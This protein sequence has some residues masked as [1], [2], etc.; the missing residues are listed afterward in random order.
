Q[1]LIELWRLIGRANKYLDETEPWALA[2]E[3]RRE[4]L[5]TV[6]YHVLETQRIV[7]LL[8]RPFMPQT[9]AKIWDQLGIEMPL[10]EQ[11]LDATRWGGLVPGTRVRPAPP[12]FPRLERE[13]DA[14][15]GET[16][17]G[18]EA[19]RAPQAQGKDG[20]A[21]VAQPEGDGAAKPQITTDEF[22]RLDLRLATVLA[23]EP[24][25]GTDRLMKLQVDL[26]HER[27]QIVAGIQGHYEPEALVGRQVVVVANLKPA[28]LRGEISQG[29]VLAAEAPD[30]TLGL[31]APDRPMPAGSQVR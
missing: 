12:L 29:M 5:A 1:A 15:D 24:V 14:E 10:E 16:E 30:G 23:A 25:A 3:G 2:R 26:G 20:M 27:R 7:A 9:A 18:G 11:L 21:A 31:I 22:A 28:K 6:M 8:L 13:D 4:R 17:L 19:A